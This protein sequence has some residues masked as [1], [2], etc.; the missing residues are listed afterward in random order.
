MNLTYG[1]TGLYTHGTSQDLINLKKKK[2]HIATKL[3]IVKIEKQM[4]THY[5]ASC[6]V[7]EERVLR[8][9]VVPE[10]KQS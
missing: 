8:C 3:I 6:G 10:E 9:D 5:S 7:V 1:L 2:N 4:R